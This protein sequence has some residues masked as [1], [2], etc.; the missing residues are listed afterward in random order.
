MVVRFVSNKEGRIDKVISETLGYSRSQVQKW[1]DARLVLLNKMGVS[2][3]E[4]VKVGD[5][6]DVFVP[7]ENVKDRKIVPTKM[8]I[9]VVYE[10]EDVI[11][12]NKPVG[13]VTH[14]VCGHPDGTLLNGLVW[15]YKEREEK[16]K[17][18][19]V[20]RLDYE[21]SGIVVFAKNSQAL[22]KISRQFLERKVDKKYMGLVYGRFKMPIFSKSTVD[23]LHLMS[24]GQK[25]GC[26]LRRSLSNRKKV[27][28]AA[29][30]RWAVSEFFP[31]KIVR[32]FSL[33]EIKPYTG[34]THQIRS[35]LKF[36]GYP[37]VGDP[38]YSG[39]IEQEKWC[40]LCLRLGIK[41]RMMLHAL[42]L[43]LI[44]P[45]GERKE[46]VANIPKEFEMVLE[47]VKKVV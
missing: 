10:D 45:S 40:N 27:V 1:I 19:V 47:N 28:V 36:L 15:Y 8:S 5:K 6:I 31:K 17:P 44:L 39:K 11:A 12:V 38:L 9:E 32:D 41:P 23:K 33:L 46:L 18:L 14:P 35:Q 22:F 21:T 29:D 3:S 26:F 30:G 24:D 37:I 2:K 20:H 13:V 42:S 25:F 43:T 34:R 16:I 7:K 4:N